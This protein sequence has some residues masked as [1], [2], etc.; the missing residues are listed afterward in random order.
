MV[1]R[2]QMAPAAYF[3]QTPF[4]HTPA[5]HMI[6]LARRTFFTAALI[7]ALSMVASATRVSAQEDV[8]AQP[9]E[10]D[11]QIAS[12]ATDSKATAPPAIAI[13]AD[14][15]PTDQPTVGDT[16][17]AD[18]KDP[19]ELQKEFMQTPEYLAELENRVTAYNKSRANLATAVAD[20][21]ETFVRYLNREVRTQAARTR[22]FEQRDIVQQRLDETFEAAL[23][24]TMI[25]QFDKDAITFLVT[26]IQHRFNNSIYDRPTLDGA[27][28]LIDNN[29]Q[30]EYIWKAAARSAVVQGEFE[31]AKTL[32]DILQKPEILGNEE[33]DKTDAALS[34]FM[35][36]HEKHYK[37]EKEI[38]EKEAAEDNL[39]RVLLKT[40]QGDVVLELFL[41]EAP[42]AVSHF[43]KLVDEMFYDGMDFPLVIQDML[44]LTGD[45][46]GNGLGHS[47]KFLKDEHEREDARH[48]LRGSLLMAKIPVD[49]TGKFFPNSGSSQFTILFLPMVSATKEQ[50]V[51]GRVIEGMDAISRLRRIDPN[52]KK[53]KDEIVQPPDSIIKATV[54]RKPKTLPEPVYVDPAN[55]DVQ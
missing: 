38:R 43:I 55:P 23:S 52:K 45:P 40:T 8:S 46:A 54:I 7:L 25:G 5:I 34:F 3:E 48:G 37:L 47:G 33:F 10:T 18:L 21:R 2:T 42:S 19:A 14:T 6:W 9:P 22:F 11:Q 31:I 27:T 4:S 49:D 1:N 26:M 15:Q 50:T 17:P 39:P 51:F 13:P 30:L 12:P 20:Q 35:D 24:L 29:S 53:E 28:L 44:A 32:Y 36:E 41:N 16:P